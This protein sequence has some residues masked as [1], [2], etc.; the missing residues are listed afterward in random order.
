M[1]KILLTSFLALPAMLMAQTTL[2]SDN[3]DSYTSGA[4]IATASAGVWEP[5]SGG[6]GTSED[7]FVSNTFSNSPSNSLNVYNTGP[8]AYLHDVVYAFPS[9]YTTGTYEIR[10]KY[11]VAAGS[12][13]YF[14]LGSVWVTGGAGYQYGMDV[15][16]NGD[17]SG[18]VNAASTGVFTYTQNA[19][20]DVSVMVDLGAG[21]GELFINSVSVFSGPWGA[22]NGFGVMDV[23][24]IAFTDATNATQI[25]A[26]FYVDD[27]TLLDWSGVGIAETNV[28]LN[29]NVFPNPNNGEFTINMTDLKESNYELTITDITGNI[30]HNESF[31]VNGSVNKTIDLNVA[32]G[33]YFAE[34]NANG[35]KVVKKLIVE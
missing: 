3:F 5:W 25:T 13:G 30:V 29:M 2:S 12:G 14:N 15:F 16:F 27:V 9:T 23:F 6:A 10:M 1:K 20:T 31:A 24:G 26:N 17:G 11:Y 21:T 33:I 4:T 22:S 18:N 7:P 28:D 34:L 19:W 32:A 35:N 8:S